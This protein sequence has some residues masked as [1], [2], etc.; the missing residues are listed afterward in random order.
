MGSVTDRQTVDGLKIQ[1]V[2]VAKASHTIIS[3]KNAGAVE[4]ESGYV[5]QGTPTCSGFDGRTLG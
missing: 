1:D 4:N 3:P 2:V 5:E